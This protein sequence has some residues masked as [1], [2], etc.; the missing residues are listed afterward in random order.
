MCQLGDEVRRKEEK[1]DS[2]GLSS[3]NFEY[4]MYNF[5]F[6]YNFMWQG[7]KKSHIRIKNIDWF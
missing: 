5:I 2:I 6:I 1:L 7:L 3:Q 4:I